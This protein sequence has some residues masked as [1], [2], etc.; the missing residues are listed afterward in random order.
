MDILGGSEIDLFT[1][2]FPELQAKFTG[3]MRL[4][5]TAIGLQ[6][7]GCFYQGSFQNIGIILS[8]AIF[9]SIITLYFI[10]KANKIMEFI[11]EEELLLKK[12]L[13]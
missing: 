8:I 4:V 7:V 6:V 11:I 13:E 10:V 12:I 3:I 2:S 5:F 9:I 1:P